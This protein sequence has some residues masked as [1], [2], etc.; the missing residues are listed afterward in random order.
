MYQK[1]EVNVN[2][3]EANVYR[4]EANEKKIEKLIGGK[5]AN[6]YM[7][8]VMNNVNTN[9]MNGLPIGSQKEKKVNVT[10]ISLFLK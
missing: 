7:T 1:K 4:K 9:G 10:K 3:K 5:E 2:K 6:D 8:E